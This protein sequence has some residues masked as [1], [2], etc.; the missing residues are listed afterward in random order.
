MKNIGRPWAYKR[1]LIIIGMDN[2]NAHKVV[3]Y[4]QRY[5][6]ITM[7]L[8]KQILPIEVNKLIEVSK[9]RYE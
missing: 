9:L 8:M 2:K 5:D 1:N 7:E 4:S 3:S 6:N